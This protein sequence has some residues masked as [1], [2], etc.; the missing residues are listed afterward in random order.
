MCFFIFF[1]LSVLGR[2]L[3]LW[4][5]KTQWRGKIFFSNCS[6]GFPETG[7]IQLSY[8]QGR[9][10]WDFGGLSAQRGVFDLPKK[11]VPVRYRTAQCE[12]R[13][14][15]SQNQYFVY[16]FSLPRANITVHKLSIDLGEIGSCVLK[17]ALYVQ[18][19]RGGCVSC[20]FLW[21]ALCKKPKSSYRAML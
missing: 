4:G 5:L 3:P 16:Q 6:T 13:P 7:K 8:Q 11:A 18:V 14:P 12:T 17:K 9:G 2:V 21:G 1:F 15:L 19:L 20:Q 10:Y